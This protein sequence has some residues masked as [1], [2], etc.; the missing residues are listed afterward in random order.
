ASRRLSH[1]WPDEAARRPKTSRR[2]LGHQ[3]RDARAAFCAAASPRGME[4]LWSPVV[5][6]G[7]NQA[8]TAWRRKRPKQAKTVAVGCDQ[9][10]ATFHGEQGVC[11]GL[12]PVAGGPFPE[13]EGVDPRPVERWIQAGANSGHSLLHNHARSA[14]RA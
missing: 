11:R 14:I 12:P 5:A 4:P 9:L 7:G 8:Q 2:N 1:R 10:L 3:S 13:K 6:T